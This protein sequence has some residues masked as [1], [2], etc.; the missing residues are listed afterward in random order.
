M[1]GLSNETNG[2]Q[3]CLPHLERQMQ[4]RNLNAMFCFRFILKLKASWSIMW[5]RHSCLPVFREGGITRRTR[6]DGR[7]ECLPHLVG[8]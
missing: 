4:F 8:A 3:E 7:Q 2:R 6:P 1:S 5:G